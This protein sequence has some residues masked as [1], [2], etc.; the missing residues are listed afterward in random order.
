MSDPTAFLREKTWQVEPGWWEVHP[1]GFSHWPFR[2]RQRIAHEELDDGFVRWSATTD[3]IR[4]VRDLDQALSLCHALN[5]HTAGWSYVVN[6]QSRTV[7][8]IATAVIQPEW[9]Q[10]YARW[11]SAATVAFWHADTIADAFA[12][13]VGGTV[14]SSHPLGASGIRAE[15][16]GMFHLVRS[17]RGRP[18]W[19]FD[20]TPARVDLMALGSQVEAWIGAKGGDSST[21][22]QVCVDGIDHELLS[23][24]AA[25]GTAPRKVPPNARYRVT[26]QFRDREPFGLGFL[27][28]IRFP[29]LGG[30]TVPDAWLANQLALDLAAQWSLSGAWTVS[31][32]AVQ[33]EIF[34]PSFTLRTM[35]N[36]SPD[37][38]LQSVLHNVVAG[39]S[40]A[41]AVADSAGQA[42]P[43]R[44]E[45][46]DDAVLPDVAADLLAVFEQPAMEAMMGVPSPTPDRADRRWLTARTF[47][48]L[49]LYG[50]FNPIGPTVVSLNLVE[51]PGSDGEF[52]VLH[53]MRHP[54][55][56]EYKE[57]GRVR[58]EDDV[59]DLIGSQLGD[60]LGSMPEFLLVQARDGIGE[61][62]V[63]GLRRALSQHAESVEEDLAASAAEYN[64]YAGRAW[65]RLNGT[66][67][68]PHS[69]AGPAGMDP[70]EDWFKAVTDLDHVYGTLFS[71]P[72]AWEGA[73]NFQLEHGSLAPFDM[74]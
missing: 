71:L 32:E 33:Y 34:V 24:S 31:E 21:E 26:G 47:A 57:L 52:A 28:R 11:V 41:M 69:E 19:A 23:A 37:Q 38:S 67:P 43:A 17:E 61:A 6:E 53:L 36:S 15:P 55:L 48:E 64:R 39:L 27:A 70:F 30:R 7:E 54:F 45:T 50:I 63:D 8:G 68:T 4:D 14:N 40:A 20:L 49:C 18:E 22:Q 35:T 65:D 12:G 46:L 73:I 5:R 72:S 74:E 60:E 10:P 59:R 16:D 9:D 58:T 62:V 51:V 29:L 25:A 44:T 13:A 42:G 1:D 66:H 2:L 56:P 3:V